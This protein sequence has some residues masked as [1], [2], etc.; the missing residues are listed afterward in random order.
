MKKVLLL[1]LAA[2]V[3]VGACIDLDGDYPAVD[4]TLIEE[5]IVDTLDETTFDTT[6]VPAT[7]PAGNLV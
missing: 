1:L 7:T 6:I 2:S 5:I 3:L 4:E